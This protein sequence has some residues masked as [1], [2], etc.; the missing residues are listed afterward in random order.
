[1]LRET[2]LLA[3]EYIGK[4]FDPERVTAPGALTSEQMD[5]GI[6]IVLIHERR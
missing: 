3:D 2:H 6:A 5:S 4:A 1:M